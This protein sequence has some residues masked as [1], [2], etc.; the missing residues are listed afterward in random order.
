MKALLKILSVAL[1]LVVLGSV[2]SSCF[3]PAVGNSDT[4]A[5][6]TPGATA[7]SDPTSAPES[8][9]T[10][11][12]TTAPETTIPE[13]TVP[14]TTVPETTVP[15][16]T[17]PET[18]VPETTVPETTVPETTV[19]ETTVPETTK[20][21]TTIPVT[22]KP[23][24]TKPATTTKPVTTENVQNPIVPNAKKA[25]TIAG[26]SVSKFS[27]IYSE[28][29]IQAAKVFALRLKQ[30]IKDVF[31]VDVNVLKDTTAATAYEIIIGK[32][33][34]GVQGASNT[35]FTLAC[36]K[37]K[38]YFASPYSV[39]YEHM[40][41]YFE[42]L[43][44]DTKG[45]FAYKNSYYYSQ[46][47]SDVLSSGSEHVLKKTGIRVMWNNVWWIDD[48]NAPFSL[49][50]PLL[51][52]V[53]RDYMP[54]V[55]GFQEYEN[56]IRSVMHPMMLEIGYLEVPYTENRDPGQTLITPVYYNPNTVKLINSG[57]IHLKTVPG[58]SGKA[59][60]WG[61]FEDKKTGKQ[62]AYAST[63][64]VNGDGENR[65]PGTRVEHAKDA[66]S[67]MKTIGDRYNVP[68][69]F[70]GD[71]NCQKSSDPIKTIQS[72][73]FEFIYDF[74][75]NSDKGATHHAYP[76]FDLSTGLCSYYDCPLPNV[77]NAIDHIFTYNHSNKVT[78][79]VYAVIED[80]FA[81]AGTDH[82]PI[83]VDFTLK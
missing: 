80:Y 81:L 72:Y 22:T 12:E 15:E 71:L 28:D 56:G 51:I 11:N 68:V 62:F 8:T 46:K 39:G 29:D 31:G 50:C 58:D 52:D 37:G 57:F 64:F 14:E 55:I 69:I 78:Y 53:Y 44:T 36:S 38:L 63:H 82:C 75:K 35:S 10:P 43:Y 30:L 74:A 23:E 76:K 54:D 83:I 77:L 6:T 79:N 41:N 59:V 32:T 70:G 66:A 60:G 9:T 27:I 45:A 13:T 67:L 19:P 4:T 7:P 20:A 17:V 21:E 65:T 24:T 3:A 26:T 18:T 34:R 49:R 25:L 2:A 73:G 16:T 42:E 61:L 48:T 40:F 1:V 5:G 47:L 33:D